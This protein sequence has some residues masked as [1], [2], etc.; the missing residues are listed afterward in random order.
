MRGRVL[1][2]MGVGKSCW[3]HQVTD[4][5]CTPSR[6]VAARLVKRAFALTTTT[7]PCR[8]RCGRADLPDSPHTIGVE[9]GTRIIEVASQKIKLQIWD[10]AGQERFRCVP[11]ATCFATPGLLTDTTR[12][13][14]RV[15]DGRG[16]WAVR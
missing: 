8:V 14:G 2:D 12:G 5:K 7:A 1:G 10:T 15:W 11:D 9:F 3:L 4:K 6:P 13:D 16:L